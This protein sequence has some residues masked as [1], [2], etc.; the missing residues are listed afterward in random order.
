MH[1]VVKETFSN[2]PFWHRRFLRQAEWTREL[3]FPL[4][5][6]LEIAR[7][8]RIL[9][10]GCGTGVIAAELAG[11]TLSEIHAVDR[12]PDL[13]AFAQREYEGLHLSWHAAEAVELPFPDGSF[14]L[15][16]TH[17]FWMWAA[18]PL[19]ILRECKRVLAPGGRV[20]ALCEPD[21]SGRRD[22]PRELSEI[23]KLTRDNL[24]ASGADPDAGP[25]LRG[26]F[27]TAGFRTESGI[28]EFAWDNERHKEEFGNEWSMIEATI[29]A[30]DILREMKIKEQGAIAAG[31]RSSVMPVHWCLGTRKSTDNSLT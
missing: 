13:I 29:G 19:D 12:D 26:L 14:D 17:Y 31:R 28:M 24:I 9:E 5:R 30:S 4:Y 16:V 27:E 10:L 8:G 22:E 3:R 18:S 11:R 2:I 21:Y 20:A 25:K 6:K 23:Y 15:I 1:F 7:A